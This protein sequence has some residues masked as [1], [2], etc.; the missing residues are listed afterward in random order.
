MNFKVAYRNIRQLLLKLGTS[1]PSV[2]I[3]KPP[4][5]PLILTSHP[6]LIDQN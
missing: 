3:S 5:D 1:K 4:V 6:L 2:R